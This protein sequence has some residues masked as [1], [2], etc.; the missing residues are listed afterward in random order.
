MIAEQILNKKPMRNLSY[1]DYK[2]YKDKFD[3]DSISC[4]SINLQTDQE[5]TNFIIE[6][7]EDSQKSIIA[8]ESTDIPEWLKND[9]KECEFIPIEALNKNCI[10]DNSK[11]NVIFFITSY[12]F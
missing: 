4:H 3:L 11:I 6:N 1:V 12:M 10:E 2:Q 7:E 8:N 5:E 9:M